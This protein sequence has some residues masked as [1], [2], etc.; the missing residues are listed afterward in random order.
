MATVLKEKG[1]VPK[2]EVAKLVVMKGSAVNCQ[3][4]HLS[5]SHPTWQAN[6]ADIK[7]WIVDLTD[8]TLVLGYTI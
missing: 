3:T 5:N 6:L 4:K 8:V 1:G 7:L 2:K